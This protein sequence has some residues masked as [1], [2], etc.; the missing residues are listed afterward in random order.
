MRYVLKSFLV[1][2]LSVGLLGVPSFAANEKPL[3][4]VTQATEAHLGSAAVAIGTTVYPGDTLATDEGGTVRLKVGGSQFYLLASSS[5]T[6]SAGSAIVNASVAR[7]TVGF[8]S[9]GTDQLSL[10]IPEGIVRAA[11][12][13]PGY[14]QVTIIGPREVIVSAYRGTLIL[15]NDGELHEIPAGKSYRVTMDLEPA[16]EPQGPAGAG[17]NNKVVA[18]R[19]RHL[20]FD[21]IILGAAGGA[22]YALWYHLSES[23]Y[24]PQ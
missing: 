14:G 20:L 19:R 13:Q 6:L 2:I 21:L 18:P 8:S 16:S 22:S 23:P 7:G 9:N 5:A 3:G 4:L 11:N 15:D 10:E 24:N 17:G 1:A 12:G